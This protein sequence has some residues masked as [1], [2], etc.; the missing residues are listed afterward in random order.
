M[1]FSWVSR[2]VAG[3]R[4]VG[5]GV[6]MLDTLTRLS[7]CTIVWCQLYLAERAAWYS[8]P[9]CLIVTVSVEHMLA[10]QL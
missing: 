9:G 4:L 3:N 2:A 10:V 1:K 6:L 7:V 8:Q 5:H